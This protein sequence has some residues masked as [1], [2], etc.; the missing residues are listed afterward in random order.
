M[1]IARPAAVMPHERHVVTAERGNTMRPGCWAGNGPEASTAAAIREARHVTDARAWDRTS[2]LHSDDDGGRRGG[3]WGRR[4]LAG[5]VLEG[6]GESTR[7]VALH[8][9]PAPLQV[10]ARVQHVRGQTGGRG[11]RGEEVRHP[12]RQLRLAEGDA[13]VRAAERQRRGADEVKHLA[14]A[15][16]ELLA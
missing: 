6:S 11:V 13:R 10:F 4:T 14:A 7:S 1:S 8:V 15:A 5:V 3:G 2:G 16:H 9:S 12:R